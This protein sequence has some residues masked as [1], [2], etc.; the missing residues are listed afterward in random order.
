MEA[1]RILEIRGRKSIMSVCYSELLLTSEVATI[2]R[3][4]KHTQCL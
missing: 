1:W 2:F 4:T 3:V